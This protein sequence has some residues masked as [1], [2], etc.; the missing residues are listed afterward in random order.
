V[1][2]L[3]THPHAIPGTDTTVPAFHL[4]TLT[5]T[6]GK[7]MLNVEVDDYGLVEQRPCGCVLGE[8]GLDVHLREIRSYSKLVGE[9]VTLVGNEMVRILEH[10][11]PSRFGGSAL[12]YQL[13]EEE[14]EER[15]TR[16]SLIVSP[17]VTITDEQEV[18]DFLHE[19]LRASSPAAGAAS[20][21]WKQAG[22][23]RVRRTEPVWTGRGKLM[24]LHIDRAARPT[25]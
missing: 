17:R 21:V 18:I 9:G 15:L 10:A 2:A 16:L 20:A 24:P 4:T 23:I 13:S 19:S 5:D 12:D 11:L 6:V 3:I 22:T 1:L 7:L 14:D 8:L 25:A